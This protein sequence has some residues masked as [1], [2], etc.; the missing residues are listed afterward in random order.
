MIIVI[1]F[2][3][4]TKQTIIQKKVLTQKSNCTFQSDTLSLCFDFFFIYEL[5]LL[6]FVMLF[7]C[8][9]LIYPDADPEFA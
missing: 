4:Q 8:V 5:L 1:A 2:N 6:I 9:S 7:L 3:K